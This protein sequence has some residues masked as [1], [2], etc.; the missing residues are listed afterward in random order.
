LSQVF[1]LCTFYFWGWDIL[2]VHHSVVSLIAMQPSLILGITLEKVGTTAAIA[3]CW[4]W[5]ILL[6]QTYGPG[7]SFVPAAKFA[8]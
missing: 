7:S 3:A 4:F 2:P 8:F 6:D 5:D 1:Y